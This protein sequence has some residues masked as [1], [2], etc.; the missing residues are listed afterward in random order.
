V[1]LIIG[2]CY[3]GVQTLSQYILFNAKVV[4][5]FEATFKKLKTI[6]TS[7]LES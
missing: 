4:V 3:H 2:Q 1:I 6:F 5:S 7:K